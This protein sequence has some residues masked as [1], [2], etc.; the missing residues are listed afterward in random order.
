MRMGS[1]GLLPRYSSR[2]TNAAH[3]GKGRSPVAV[4]H[5]RSW[6]AV[7]T[8]AVSA[9]HHLAERPVPSAVTPTAAALSSC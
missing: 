9:V 5:P 2:A 3:P 8:V 4:V 6:A 1:Q 7:A